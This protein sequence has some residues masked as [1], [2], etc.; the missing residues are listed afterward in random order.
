MTHK[1]QEYLNFSLSHRFSIVG[2]DAHI[3]PS[4]KFDLDEQYFAYFCSD[5]FQFWCI[6]PRNRKRADVGIGPYGVYD[7]L[8][9]RGKKSPAGG[10]AGQLIN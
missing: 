3:G 9:F 1:G 5:W 4:M 2:A 8:Q 6:E 7:K 10:P